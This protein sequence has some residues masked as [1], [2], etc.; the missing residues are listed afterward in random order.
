MRRSHKEESF[1]ECPAIKLL[2]FEVRE[3]PSHMLSSSELATC[4]NIMVLI[5]E[6][7]TARGYVFTSTCMKDCILHVAMYLSTIKGTFHH[8]P[9]LLFALPCLHGHPYARPLKR[10]SMHLHPAAVPGKLA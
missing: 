4:G 10:V 7:T 9:Q 6:Y 2:V 5:L 8:R 3:E 1:W